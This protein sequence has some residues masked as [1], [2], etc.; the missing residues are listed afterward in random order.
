MNHE[1]FAARLENIAMATGIIAGLS[2]AAATIAT[3]T[4]LSAFGVWLGL[5]DEP[6]I[7]TAAPILDNLATVSGT[8]SGM[9]YFYVMRK[10][11]KIQKQSEP[12]N[13]EQS[14]Y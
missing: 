14:D 11:R 12:D 9:S 13:S 7:V 3:P 1:T 4:G 8:I 10:K 6:L 5:M 2:A